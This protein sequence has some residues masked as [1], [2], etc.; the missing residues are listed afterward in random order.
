MELHYANINPRLY[1]YIWKPDF[2]IV[3]L[4]KLDTLD[5]NREDHYRILKVSND[6]SREQFRHK[7]TIWTEWDNLD[8][9]EQFGENWT[10]WR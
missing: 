2:N 4:R 5:K 8:I 1:D 6:K 3:N 9:M 10:I 7:L